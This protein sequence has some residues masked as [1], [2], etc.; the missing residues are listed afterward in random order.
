MPVSLTYPGVYIEELPSGVRTITGVATSVA[1]FVGRAW[2]GPVDQPATLFSYADYERIFGGLWRDSAM[3]YAVQQFFQNGGSQAVVV[4]V[5]TRN[6]QH[7]IDPTAFATTVDLGNGFQ[8]VAAGPG[9]WADNLT[10]TIDL[11]TKD[12]QDASPQLFNLT[13]FDDPDKKADLRKL[14]G[15]GLRETFLNV[16]MDASNPRFVSQVL[17]QQSVLARVLH[18]AS[19]A[20]RPSATAVTFGTGAG[21]VAG[22]DGI[23]LVDSDV[24]GQS[25]PK[26]GIYALKKTDIFN[27]LCL[28]PLT[29][30][31][32]GNDIATPTW[33]TASQFCRD[34]RA[35]L[36]VDAPQAWDVTAA[37]DTAPGGSG[38]GAFSALDRNHSAIYFPAPAR[39]RSAAGEQA[40]RVRAVRGRRRHL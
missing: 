30:G 10:A 12:A 29:P 4:R 8:L 6:A 25:D 35:F 27:L 39:P 18:P 38:I 14:G 17:K 37:I 15:S 19:P 13:L 26:T 22:S 9:S 5:M 3:S 28:P 1:A 7:Q 20:A 11:N 33:A 2:R 32:T 31:A 24:V 21:S 34:R 40:R 16:S 36:I 23:A